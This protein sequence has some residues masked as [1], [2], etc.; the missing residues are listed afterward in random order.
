MQDRVQVSSW[1][2]RHNTGPIILTLRQEN[3]EIKDQQVTDG[4]ENVALVDVPEHLKSTFGVNGIEMQDFNILR[5]SRADQDRLKAAI[6]ENGIT[7]GCLCIENRC[8]G[9]AEQKYRDV[10]RRYIED[11]LVLAGRLGAKAARIN[12]HNPPVFPQLGYAT[13]DVI[14]EELKHLTKFAEDNGTQLVVENHDEVTNSPETMRRIFDAVGPGLGF[15]LDTGNM[16]P[17]SD[18]IMDSFL[19]RRPPRWVENAE[20]AFDYIEAMLPYATI[21]HVKTYGFE[22]D[23]RAMV[24]DQK[25][26][27]DMIAASAFKGP[28]TIECASPI[29]PLVY[30]AIQR[31]V[32]MLR[33][34]LH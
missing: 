29:V 31:T 32:D 19:N 23:G 16:P 13:V 2:I 27:V 33:Q 15:I 24:Y 22:E 3:G 5:A 7:L 9:E 20:P 30:P 10:D 14:I 4:E 6:D 28:V 21:V 17:I 34:A 12:V 8:I 25:R 11:S 26:A 1:G 18:E